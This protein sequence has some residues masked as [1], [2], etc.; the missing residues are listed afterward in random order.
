MLSNLLFFEVGYGKEDMQKMRGKPETSSS[1]IFERA[2]EDTKNILFDSWSLATS[3]VRWEGRDW[4][5]AGSV[6]LASAGVSLLDQEIRRLGL[7]RDKN[8]NKNKLE[9]IGSTWGTFVSV[10]L[11]TGIS[12]GEGII[13]GSQWARDTGNLLVSSLFMA[14]IISLVGKRS[15]GRLRPNNNSN[16][17]FFKPFNDDVAYHSSPSGHLSYAWTASFA[18][19]EQ[20][21]S[22]TMKSFF[23]G[24][25]ALSGFAR[26]YSNAHWPSD[27]AFTGFVSYFIVK[28]EKK[29]IEKRKRAKRLAQ[30]GESETFASKNSW[31]WSIVPMGRSLHLVIDY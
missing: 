23:W 21:E 26:I 3:P 13:R 11:V 9:S 10:G 25:G 14:N 18:L 19:A 24:L 28:N 30:S 29:R 27:V 15:I 8:R 1:A 4:S 31:D 7:F 6:V 22:L 2:K 16:Q 5:M 20:M 12:L 17:Y